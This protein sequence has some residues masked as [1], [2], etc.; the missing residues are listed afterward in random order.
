MMAVVMDMYLR[1]RD[2]RED[3]D[4][5]QKEIAEYLNGNQSNYSKTERGQRALSLD[6]AIKLAEL[7]KVSLDYLVGLTD[8]RTPYP[9]SRRK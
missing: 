7:Y 6:D 8:E 3:A 1:I 4:L 5:T 9:R 2:L